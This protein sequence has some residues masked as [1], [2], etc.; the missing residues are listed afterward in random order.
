MTLEYTAYKL[1][2]EFGLKLLSNGID[3]AKEKIVIDGIRNDI[4]QFNERYN[5]TELDG[6]SRILC[7][8]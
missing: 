8:R 1:A 6:V 2:E 4:C 5:D 7:K 3:R